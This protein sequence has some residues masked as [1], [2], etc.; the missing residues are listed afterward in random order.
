MGNGKAKSDFGPSCVFGFPFAFMCSHRP[1][2]AYECKTA[3]ECLYWRRDVVK[4]IQKL[5]GQI[6]NRMFFYAVCFY[7]VENLPEN[8]IRDLNDEINRLVRA[9]GH[10]DRRIRELGG[11]ILDAADQNNVEEDEG[12]ALF[13][14][15]GNIYKYKMRFSF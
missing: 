15:G 1:L 8:S 14:G 13:I 6:Q 5:V 11:V 2:S 9:K 7:Y 4:Q 10:W 3:S 12:D